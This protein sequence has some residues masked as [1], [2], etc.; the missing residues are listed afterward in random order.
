MNIDTAHFCA[1]LQKHIDLS[2]AKDESGKELS[3]AAELLA[4]Q[5]EAAGLREAVITTGDGYALVWTGGRR[6]QDF[7]R[8]R[9]AASSG[10]TR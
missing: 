4:Q 3:A 10:E 6:S 8:V 7:Q 2:A 9:M 5:L 1:A